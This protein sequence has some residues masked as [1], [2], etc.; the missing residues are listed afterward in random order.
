VV[1]HI[2]DDVLDALADSVADDQQQELAALEVTGDAISTE[3]GG[4]RRHVVSAVRSPR[5]W[6]RFP[7]IF[8]LG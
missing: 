1:L 6:M 7:Y 8:L 3:S 4:M 5:S 2:G